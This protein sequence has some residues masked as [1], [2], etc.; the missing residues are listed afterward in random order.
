MAREALLDQVPLVPAQVHPIACHCGP[1]EAAARYEARLRAFFDDE[2]PAFDLI[3]LG[4]GADGHTAS[5][6]PGSPALK[7]TRWVA[8]VYREAENLHRVT[9]T[10]ALINQAHMVAFLVTGADKAEVLGQILKRGGAAPLPAQHIHPTSGE[11]HWL[12]DKAAAA[13]M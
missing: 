13:G 7:E 12:V 3:L 10:P 5:L 2:P 8:A 6:F 1:E 9:L 4:L 11:L